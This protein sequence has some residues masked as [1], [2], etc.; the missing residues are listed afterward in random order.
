MR[1]T[2]WGNRDGVTVVR[3]KLEGVY[4]TFC[5]QTFVFGVKLVWLL[6]CCSFCCT[7]Y[8]CVCVVY[9]SIF[10]L[11]VLVFFCVY[12]FFRQSP[13]QQKEAGVV[14]R[15]RSI[16]SPLPLTGN[17]FD[18]PSAFLTMG[19]VQAAGVR[20]NYDRGGACVPTNLL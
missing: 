11:F 19:S 20:D 1:W 6:F 10:C 17:E 9:I 14:R 12:P 4:C 16:S 8:V 15:S 2:L 18:T 7:R 13:V 3:E 5:F